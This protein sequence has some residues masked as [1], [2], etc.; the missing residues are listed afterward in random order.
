MIRVAAGPWTGLVGLGEE[1][2]R[3][4]MPRAEGLLKEALVDFEGRVKRTLTGKRTGR[5]YKVSKTGRMHIASA[6]DEPPAVLTGALRN[7]VG[8]RGPLWEAWAIAGEV[9]VGLGTK[10]DGGASDPAETY[11]RRL[12]LGGIDSRGVFIFRRPYLA[13]TAETF[14]PVLTRLFERGL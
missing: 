11:A 2:L 7:S 12:E 10:P 13:P 3:S 9:G 6:P 14:E 5:P 1:A 8:H 4:L